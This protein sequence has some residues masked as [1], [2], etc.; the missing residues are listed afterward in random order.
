MVQA[1]SARS[2]SGRGSVGF[3]FLAGAVGKA[4]CISYT[5]QMCI[6]LHRNSLLL[7]QMWTKLRPGV[8]DFLCRAAACF[9]LWIHTKG[10]RCGVGPRGG[11]SRL[12]LLW[13]GVA[14]DV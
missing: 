7:P 2:I 12:P 13:S 4:I 9:E 14:A 1:S 6:F 10:S 8:Q 5:K 11:H 3:R